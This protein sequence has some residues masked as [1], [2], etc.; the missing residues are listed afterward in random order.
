MLQ[1]VKLSDDLVV[2]YEQ[3]QAQSVKTSNRLFASVHNQ[4]GRF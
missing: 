3:T 4:S 2:Q 1:D